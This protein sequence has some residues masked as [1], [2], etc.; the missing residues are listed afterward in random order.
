MDNVAAKKRRL[1]YGF[2]LPAPQGALIYFLFIISDIGT[3]YFTLSKSWAFVLLF[4]F[5]TFTAYLFVGLQSLLWTYAV[6]WI[7]G[8]AGI[9]SVLYYFS[10]SILGSISG[11]TL[12]LYLSVFVWQVILLG[13]FIGF[14]TAFILSKI[15]N[16][17]AAA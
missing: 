11:I 14:C 2:L 13:I 17:V 9:G 5:I 1:L 10:A 12:S 4:V 6:E 3:D 16:N 8:K 15:S 7:G